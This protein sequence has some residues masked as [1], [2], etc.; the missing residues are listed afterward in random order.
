MRGYNCYEK[1]KVHRTTN[2]LCLE[3]G[4]NRHSGSRSLPQNGHLGGNVFQLET[5][6]LRFGNRRI[7]TTT[8]TRRRELVAQTGRR[9]FDAR[10]TDAAGRA[11]KKA[12]RARERR[13]LAKKLIDEYR[14]SIRR[15]CRICLIARSLVY[16]KLQGP[17]DDRAVRACDGQE[18]QETKLSLLL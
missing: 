6:V 18:K 14:V 4:G 10:Q 16:Y 9:R 12:L 17:R 13:R 7:A 1:I 2:C 5:E 15:A 3:I 11:E 8:A